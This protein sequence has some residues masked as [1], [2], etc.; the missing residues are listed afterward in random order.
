M[1]VDEPF[2]LDAVS[3]TF[4]TEPDAEI[5]LLKYETCGGSAFAAWC[6]LLYKC[7]QYQDN[8]KEMELIGNL[9]GSTALQGT[10]VP[11]TLVAVDTGIPSHQQNLAVVTSPRHSPQPQCSSSP[12]Q[13]QHDQQQPASARSDACTQRGGGRYGNE[14]GG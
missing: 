12:P 3:S 1:D 4:P 14:R 8:D 5:S 9:P 11:A 2:A 7:G 10:P 13:F 6:R